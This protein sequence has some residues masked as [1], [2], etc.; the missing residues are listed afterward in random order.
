MQGNFCDC[1]IFYY[2]LSLYNSQISFVQSNLESQCALLSLFYF[3]SSDKKEL[4]RKK[5]TKVK[6]PF[7]HPDH[8]QKIDFRWVQQIGFDFFPSTKEK[9]NRL[10]ATI[11]LNKIKLYKNSKD[12][13]IY[14]YQEVPAARVH[15]RCANAHNFFGSTLGR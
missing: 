1:S 9:R 12:E 10:S 7:D 5:Y 11:F 8:L 3:F 15:P 14:L 2:V 13:K 4:T 6:L